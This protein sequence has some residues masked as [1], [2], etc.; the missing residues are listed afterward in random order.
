[1]KRSLPKSLCLLVAGLCMAGPVVAQSEFPAKPL[2]LVIPFAPGGSADLA[3][4]VL[5]QKMGEFLGQPVVSEN[6]AGANSNLGAEAVAKSAPDGYTMLYNTS[7]VVFNM[8]LYENPGY[9]LMRD[10]A[11]VALTATVPQILVVNP[12]LPVKNLREFIAYVKANSGKL[13]YPSVGQGNIGHLTTEM[14]LAANGATAVHVSYNGSAQAYVDLIS[15]RTQFY[16]GTVSASMGHVKDKR[17]QAIAVTSMERTRSHP[18]IP[19]MNESGMPRFEAGAW[20]GMLVPART[21]AAVIERLNADVNKALK[22]PDL[23]KQ[24]DAQGT[25]ALGSTPQQYGAYLKSELERW[26]KIIR[27]LKL[28]IN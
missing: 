12:S 6:R 2:R 5:G 1:M 23:L 26:G 28:T 22:S 8:S 14:F 10:F 13:N 19:T 18:D 15:G 20:Q 16:F 24:F 7:G 4:R 9:D 11:P 17:L 21:P 25:Q 27:E 3:A